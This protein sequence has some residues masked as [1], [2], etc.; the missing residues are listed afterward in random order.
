MATVWMRN[1]TP[2]SKHWGPEIQVT[3]CSS[4]GNVVTVVQIFSFPLPPFL[5]KQKANHGGKGLYKQLDHT[6]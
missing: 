3:T 5:L 6:C 1:T 2:G 4:Q